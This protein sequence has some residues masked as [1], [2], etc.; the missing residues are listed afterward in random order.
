MKTMIYKSLAFLA[1]PLLSLT[2]CND[3]LVQNNEPI[4]SMKRICL[5]GE[6]DQIAL[7]R[8]N[9]NGFCNGDVM[10]VYIGGLRRKQSRHPA[11]QR[12]PWR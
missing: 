8:V 11:K 7:T 12:K 1:L 2:A 5:S 6:I 3:D 10:C 9:D 4:N